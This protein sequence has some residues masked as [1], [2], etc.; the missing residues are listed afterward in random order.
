MG[1]KQNFKTIK[2]NNKVFQV[3]TKL[4]T[5]LNKIKEST[6]LWF[7][8]LEYCDLCWKIDILDYSLNNIIHK[9]TNDLH[10]NTNYLEIITSQS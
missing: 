9:L 7:K 4:R 2:I 6:H 10:A 1:V 3:P 5:K 8:K